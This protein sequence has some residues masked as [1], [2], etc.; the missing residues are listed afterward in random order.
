MKL[1]STLKKLVNSYP[2]T[3]I[4]ILLLLSSI[5]AIFIQSHVYAMS[6]KDNTPGCNCIN[7][8]CPKTDFTPPSG[9]YNPDCAQEGTKCVCRR[10]EV[11]YF[12]A[13]NQYQVCSGTVVGG[14]NDGK[15]CSEKDCTHTPTGC[16]DSGYGCDFPNCGTCYKGQLDKEGSKC[17][18]TNQSAGCAT[19]YNGCKYKIVGTEDNYLPPS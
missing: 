2:I 14:C 5:T 6:Q 11:V 7:K 16:T 15:P 19:V 12:C 3:L 17:Y 18:K 4:F 1:T 13:Q 9:P 10:S 8:D